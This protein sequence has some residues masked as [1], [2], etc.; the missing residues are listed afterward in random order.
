M[1]AVLLPLP[2]ADER[3]LLN[4]IKALAPKVQ[5]KGAALLLDGR[6]DL[7]ARAGADGAHLSGIEAFNAALAHAQAGSDRRLRRARHPP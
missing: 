4:G 3:T 2:A 1:A 5:D 7:A 6:A